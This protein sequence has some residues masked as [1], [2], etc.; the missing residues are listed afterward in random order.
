MFR[1]WN[2]TTNLGMQ[3]LIPMPATQCSTA[4]A[5]PTSITPM[6][7]FFV[8]SLCLSSQRALRL[9]RAA[10]ADYKTALN[11]EVDATQTKKFRIR[12]I[13]NVEGVAERA[14]GYLDTF[15]VARYTTEFLGGPW[16]HLGEGIHG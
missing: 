15:A 5:T 3:L 10:G 1:S 4:P 8:H 14:A 11:S 13:W 2:C 7:A 16:S 6:S 12:R 9:C